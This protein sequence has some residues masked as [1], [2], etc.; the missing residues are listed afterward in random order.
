MPSR[1][2]FAFV[3][4]FAIN[5]VLVVLRRGSFELFLAMTP[6]IPIA[7]ISLCIGS[8]ILKFP[9]VSRGERRLATRAIVFGFVAGSCFISLPIGWFV[10]WYDIGQAK[11]FCDRLRPE[12]ERYRSR[13]G[14]Y[15]EQLSQVTTDVQLPRILRQA[16]FYRPFEGYY[17]FSFRNHSRIF[18]EIEFDSRDGVWCKWD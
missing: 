7:L 11:S 6:L 9:G 10:N 13:T 18:S 4:S 15:P 1:F 17:R 12:L 14:L 5:L 3:A 2:P 16:K 8:L